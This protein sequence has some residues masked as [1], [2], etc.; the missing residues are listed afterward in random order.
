MPQHNTPYTQLL[1]T[2]VD[3]FTES[4]FQGNPLAIVHLPPTSEF[5]PTQSQ[6][7]LIASEFNLSETIFLEHPVTSDTDNSI[8]RARIF[9]TVRE[10][11]FA[12][13]PTIGAA[14]HLLVHSESDQGDIHTLV[15]GAGSI[16][17]S[18]IPSQPGYVK[19]VIPQNYHHHVGRLP[20]SRL[21]ALHST[22]RPF[23]KE[24]ESFPIVSIVHG[25][26][27]ILVKVPDLEALAAAKL[28]NQSANILA[29]SGVLDQGWEYNAPIAVYLYVRVAESSQEDVETIRTRMLVRGI[30]DPATGSAASALT[31]FLTLRN[32]TIY[33]TEK[34]W[35]VIQGVEMGRRS[36]IAVRVSLRDG[37]IDTIELSG[38]AV[39]ASEGTIRV[40]STGAL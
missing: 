29:D 26:T 16:P 1:F 10:I 20:A 25:M 2:I 31:A 12:G 8:R 30:E 40:D 5:N 18:L 34:Q 37:T 14:T 11:L 38:T 24:I 22:L 27:F 23:V 36:E 28:G 13:H 35:K 3:V 4:R 17:I 7:Q 33:G 19:A 39:V 15:P 32:S 21:L 9:T 6:L